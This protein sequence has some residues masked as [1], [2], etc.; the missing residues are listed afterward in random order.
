[1]I[2]K[3]RDTGITITCENSLLPQNI[4]NLKGHGIMILRLPCLCALHAYEGKFTVIN[5]LSTC[6]D[7]TTIKFRIANNLVGQNWLTQKPL[8]LRDLWNNTVSLTD[9]AYKL[10]VYFD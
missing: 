3:N 6:A 10:D 2:S 1:M 7:D 4:D 9:A 5:K 8:P